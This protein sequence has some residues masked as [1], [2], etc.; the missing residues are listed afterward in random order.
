MQKTEIKGGANFN[1]M[2]A[3]NQW[4]TRPD[5]QRFTTLEELQTAVD[6]RRNRSFVR[7]V[8]L[9]DLLAVP[10]SEHGIELHTPDRIATPSNW[11]FGQLCSSV[12]APAAYLR[13]LPA[14]LAA[15][16]L[17][18]GLSRD[19]DTEGGRQANRLLM[20]NA[21][22]DALPFSA[23]MPKPSLA[24]VTSTGY[25]R[26]WDSDVVRMV[27]Q[28]QRDH[29][30]FSNPLAYGRDGTPEPSGLYASDRDCF[31]F[32]IDG[33]SFLDAGTRADGKRDGLNRGFIVWNSEVGKATFGF[34][35]F[36]FRGV[37]GNHIIWG[38]QDLNRLTIRHSKGGPGRFEEE[39]LPILLDHVHASAR[40][41]EAAIRAA[42]SMLLPSKEKELV[43]FV[44]S[45]IT[46]SELRGALDYAS[47]EEGLEIRPDDKGGISGNLWQLVNG[48]TAQA[49]DLAH[50]DARTDLERRSSKLMDKA[51]KAMKAAPVTVPGISL[52]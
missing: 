3:S 7:D 23:P 51:R 8:P 50:I 43:A 2:K 9:K 39:A 27:R 41:D 15:T 42:Q 38:C 30:E 31:M 36:M 40:E 16:N 22:D 17:N 4:M 35:T 19:T 25:G 32:L 6:S 12:G 14:E 1:Y 46:R 13:R 44:G 21:D 34:E 20:T 45:S 52:N 18:H 24:A 26:I 11:S 33:G 48:F 47:R 10:V 5:D 29:P 49:R 28:V 37:C